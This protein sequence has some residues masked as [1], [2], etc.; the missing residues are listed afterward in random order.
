MSLKS[1]IHNV[2]SAP[3]LV[4]QVIS[5]ETLEA[6][7][8]RLCNNCERLPPPRAAAEAETRSRLPQDFFLGNALTPRPRLCPCLLWTSQ[9]EQLEQVM[10][11]LGLS[12]QQARVLL[13]HYR[14][15]VETLL[16]AYGD[17]QEACFKRAG[18]TSSDAAAAAQPLTGA[19]PQQAAKSPQ[20]PSLFLGAS[21]L[22]LPPPLSRAPHN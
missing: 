15:N 17:D 7:Q 2:V 21:R 20:N 9:R 4:A 18:L 22:S 12:K 11:V 1:K 6:A 8:V 5:K 19:G 3:R 13:I 10:N 14:W 16:S